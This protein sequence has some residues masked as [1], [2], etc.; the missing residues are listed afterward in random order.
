MT[1]VLEH[2]F[3]LKTHI[4]ITK[5]E[6]HLIENYILNQEYNKDNSIIIVATCKN[7]KEFLNL[8]EELKHIKK[9]YS[10]I[11]FISANQLCDKKIKNL[12]FNHYKL[13]KYNTN[14]KYNL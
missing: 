6:K 1:M 3:N 8:K 10:L 12:I 14:I 5:I 9:P 13:S 2:L 4:Q 11:C 7:Y